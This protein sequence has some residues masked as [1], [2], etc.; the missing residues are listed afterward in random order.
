MALLIAGYLVFYNNFKIT[1][2]F[3]KYGDLAVKIGSVQKA[4]GKAKLIGT[5]RGKYYLVAGSLHG[6]VDIYQKPDPL[7]Q[8][9]H[10]FVL[11]KILDFQVREIDRK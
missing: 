2:M 5:L 10:R 9:Q 4:L 8:P 3:R 11:Q 1:S 7:T 6:V